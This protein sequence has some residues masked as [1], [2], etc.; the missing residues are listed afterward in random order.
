MLGTMRSVVGENKTVADCCVKEGSKKMA[1]LHG[2]PT[3]QEQKKGI[4]IGS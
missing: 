4:T 3:P 1:D 2:Q